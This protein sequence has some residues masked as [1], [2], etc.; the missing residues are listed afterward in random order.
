[1]PAWR[2]ALKIRSQGR[3]SLK[4]VFR[5]ETISA[6]RLNSDPGNDRPLQTQEHIKGMI[7]NE[8]KIAKIQH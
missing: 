2:Q 7:N 6:F 1:M 3:P 8:K 5:E 4:R